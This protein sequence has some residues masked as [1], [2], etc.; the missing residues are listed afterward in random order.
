MRALKFSSNPGAIGDTMDADRTSE[1][2]AKMGRKVI[3]RAAIAVSRGAEGSA[4]WLHCS[5]SKG[6]SLAILALLSACGS[7][8]PDGLFPSRP[9]ESRSPGVEVHAAPTGILEDPLR[10]LPE[11]SSQSKLLVSTS[12][13]DVPLQ[14]LDL[15]AGRTFGISGVPGGGLQLG[16]FTPDGGVAFVASP[17]E[18]GFL[19]PSGVRRPAVM[20]LPASTPGTITALVV[21]GD[22]IVVSTG[23]GNPGQQRPG[24]SVV[25]GPDGML[26]CEGPEG[27][28][29]SW[30]RA[31]SVWSLDLRSRLDPASC[32]SSSGL[33]LK[34]N[35]GPLFFLD[36]GSAGYLSRD[37]KSVSRFDLGTGKVAASSSNLPE[38]ISN[39]V[40]HGG[41]VL[42]LAGGE[43]VRLD[44]ATLKVKGSQRL[45]ECAYTPSLVE[46]NQALYLLDDCEGVLYRLSESL[47]LHEG[48]RLPLD[49]GSDIEAFGVGTN[50]GIWLVDVEQSGEPYFFNARRERFEQIP[51]ELKEE[52]AIYALEFDLHPK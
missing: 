33:D 30:F 24:R 5:G 9:A 41:D 49:E 26:R 21:A 13:D 8:Q 28:V 31:G 32:A 7:Y 19:E 12:S 39:A 23:I 43:L 22:A 15:A 47:L 36:Q 51:A 37:G 25:L 29:F 1:V 35:E 16:A 40:L 4:G 38:F 10:G 48:W 14:V 44:S 45:L 46:Q 34:G 18:V 50:E 42:V 6:L 20:E 11:T 2:R 52:I 3:R 27:T 17:R